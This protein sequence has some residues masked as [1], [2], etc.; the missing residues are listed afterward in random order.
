[1]VAS[2]SSRM[3][4]AVIVFC[5]TAAGACCS[6]SVPL[7]AIVVSFGAFS[8][9]EL[10]IDLV[11][12]NPLPAIEPKTVFGCRELA[13]MPVSAGVGLVQCR[14]KL[15]LTWRKIA[16]ALTDQVAPPAANKT[17]SERIP[18]P[19]LGLGLFCLALWCKL[20]TLERAQLSPL[21]YQKAT[22]RG[23]CE[24]IRRDI[25]SG[26]DAGVNHVGKHG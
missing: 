6:I 12:R 3:S 14:V 19:A 18:C 25:R 16:I 20:E 1:M 17:I 13:K 23:F 24:K 7:I 26:I 21:T 11:D 9:V 2:G 4:M 22:R 15:F 10:S 8:F 5:T